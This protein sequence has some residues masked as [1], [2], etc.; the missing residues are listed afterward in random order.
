MYVRMARGISLLWNKVDIEQA[1][2]PI[3]VVHSLKMSLCAPAV[4]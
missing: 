1:K 2:I 3:G 4:Y